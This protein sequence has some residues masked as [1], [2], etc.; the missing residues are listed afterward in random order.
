MIHRRSVFCAAAL[1]AAMLPSVARPQPA[2]L[3][4]GVIQAST[5]LFQSTPIYVAQEKGMLE[6]E[7]ISL[8][9]VPLPG[10]EHMIL[11]LDK[12][13]VD[14]SSTATPYLI[15]L[16]LKGSRAVAVVGG[17]ANTIYHIVSRP[18]ITSVEGLRGKIV[19][20]SLPVDM[21]SITTRKILEKHGL[22]EPAFTA[23]ELIGTP[24]RAQCLESGECAA[25]PLSQPDD[26][27][28]GRKGFHLL[29]D[30]HEIIS[31]LQFTVLAARRD[32]AVQHKDLLVRFARAMGE[33][34]RFT[35]DPK[36]R[37]EIV[38]IATKAT[39]TSDDIVRETYKLFYEPD[40]GAMPKHGEISLSGLSKVIE[41]LGES[42]TL[43]QP[44]PA[45]GRFV[46]LQFLQA[47]GMQ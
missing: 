45:A 13:S 31:D 35:A 4:L 38:A 44:L 40:I 6:R 36:N 20:V 23:K 42:G 32:W 18:E 21:I 16:A 24:L 33:A 34:Y 28:F 43:K 19:G 5:R 14:I 41:L 29:A 2:Q 3:R 22:V 30:S 47:A 46:D 15:D 17:P 11:E 10:V 26:I 9:V 25:A 37:D 8:D 39:G 27:I 7:G 1:L 12:G